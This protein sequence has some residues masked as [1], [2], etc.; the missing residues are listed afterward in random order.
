MADIEAHSQCKRLEIES[1][2]ATRSPT[3]NVVI[4]SSMRWMIPVEAQD[5]GTV[6]EIR[7]EEGP[8]R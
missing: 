7:C 1:R 6:K 8:V 4:S 3:A 5:D 2:P